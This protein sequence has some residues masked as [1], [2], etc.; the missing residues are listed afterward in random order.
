MMLKVRRIDSKADRKKFVMMPWT[1]YKDDPKWVPPLLFDRLET[2]DPKKNPFFDHAEVALFL[3]EEDG[4]PVGRITAHVNH[5]HN[6][7][8]KD[9]T[10]FFGFFEAK[11]DPKV[12]RALLDEAEGWLKDRGRDQVL[13]PES[14]STLWAIWRGASGIAPTV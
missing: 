3:A 14:F 11:N 12:A 13:G 4:E 1:I 5:L 2:I 6:E 10:G 8:H 7:Y 9:K